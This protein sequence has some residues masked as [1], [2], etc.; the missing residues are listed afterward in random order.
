MP[1]PISTDTRA[2]DFSDDPL[3]SVETPPI[4]WDA[5][6]FPVTPGGRSRLANIRDRNF[7]RTPLHDPCVASIDQDH[8]LA[9]RDAATFA[10][11]LSNRS[12]DDD[13]TQSVFLDHRPPFNWSRGASS[14]PNLYKEFLHAVVTAFRE[15]SLHGHMIRTSSSRPIILSLAISLSTVRQYID[16]VSLHDTALE[17]FAILADYLEPLSFS[18]SEEYEDVL[19]GRVTDYFRGDE[20]ITCVV[21][22]SDVQVLSFL[23]GAFKD[24]VFD[25]SESIKTAL[26]EYLEG[27]L[28]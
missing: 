22:M 10:E 25:R 19:G 15:E 13:C 14:Q 27:L 9:F 20:R 21:S 12:E 18:M 6:N 26:V 3:Y 23:Q 2:D 8:H 28:G 16:E 1:T 17:Y 4:V 7:F 24:D 11:I 5:V